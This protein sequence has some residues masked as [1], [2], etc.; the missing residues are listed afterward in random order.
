M[1]A[2]AKSD[3]PGLHHSSWDVATIDDVGLGMEQMTSN[4]ATRTVGAWDGT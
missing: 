2:F 4:A 1:L 3:G